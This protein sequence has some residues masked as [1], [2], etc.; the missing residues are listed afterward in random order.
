MLRSREPPRMPVIVAKCQ[1]RR[2]TSVC[3]V[4]YIPVVLRRARELP[5]RYLAFAPAGAKV[6]ASAP[7][8]AS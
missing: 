4:T 7:L 2:R 6:F 3:P 8:Q 1:L 5:A